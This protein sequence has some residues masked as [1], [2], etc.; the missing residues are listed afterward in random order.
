MEEGF[1]QLILFE[2]DLSQVAAG[3]GK[4]G[5]ALHSQAEVLDGLLPLAEE[6]EGIAQVVVRRRQVRL[7]A[8]S[9]PELG[10]GGF[11]V[12]LIAQGQTEVDGR[13][14]ERGLQPQRRATASD[15]PV[16][17][18]ESAIGFG[19]V[20]VE[21]SHIGPQSDGLADQLNGLG[22]VALL[23][24]EHAKQVQGIGVLLLASQHL[25]IEP[26]SRSQLS[27]LMHFNSGRQN[28]LYGSTDLHVDLDTPQKAIGTCLLAFHGS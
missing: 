11:R 14:R 20:G 28:V 7:E 1:V 27:G 21:G 5:G 4:I 16:Q 18:A 6:A 19:E 25:P 10:D 24:A 3:G 12:A 26:V 15:G 9:G 8:E 13:F 22:L 2:Q 17:L 23:M